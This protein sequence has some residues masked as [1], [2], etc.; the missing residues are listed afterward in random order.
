MLPLI[1]Q[2]KGISCMQWVK[3]SHH[4][5][6]LLRECIAWNEHVVFMCPNSKQMPQDLPSY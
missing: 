3:S 6:R 2:L 5:W 4:P 1:Y